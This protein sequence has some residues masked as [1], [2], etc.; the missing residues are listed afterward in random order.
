MPP[1]SEEGKARITNIDFF[2]ETSV[3]M[4]G[5]VNANESGNYSL[6]EVTPFL[7]TDLNTKYNNSVQIYTITD[8][9][10]KYPK[11]NDEFVQDLRSGQILGGKSSQLQ[12]VFGSII[13]SVQPNSVSIL[14]TDCIVDLGK[15]N[16]RTESSL[17]TQKIYKHLTR[18][19]NFGA[20]VFQYESDFNGDHYYDMK[21]TGGK[22]I[23]KHPYYNTVLHKRPFYVW[24]FG[25]KE[26]VKEV[27]SNNIFGT[28]TNSYF[29]NLPIHEVSFKILENPK[30]GKVAINQEK[31]TVLIR[32]ASEKRPAIFTL[33][34]NLN[35]VPKYYHEQFEDLNNFQITPK[36]IKGIA[37]L[38]II[39]DLSNEKKVDNSTISKHK[40]SHFIQV[41]FSNVDKDINQ[42]NIQL[43]QDAAK[44]FDT[45]HLDEDF[46][47]TA[48]ELEGKTFAFKCITDA[49]ERYS[50]DKKELLNVQLTKINK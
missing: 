49:F 27:L 45:V 35:E 41:Q 23:K 29:F 43:T 9:P 33:G 24:V 15:I 32:E 26:A 25:E 16:T 44:W 36:Y 37:S 13:D 4:K 38:K 14:V 10:E 46:K 17:V 5:Y 47:I 50:K 6:K 42:I 2:I 19:K 30:Q 48:Q 1:N 39:T 12:H 18:K 3:S 34:F 40:L 22:N 31:E 8:S 21:N 11:S 28:Y 20:A 7:I